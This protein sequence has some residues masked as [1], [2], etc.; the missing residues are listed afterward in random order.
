MEAEHRKIVW[1]CCL[2]SAFSVLFMILG[3]AICLLAMA[4]G[5]FDPRSVIGDEKKKSDGEEQKPSPIVEDWGHFSSVPKVML[6]SGGRNLQLTEDFSY[7]DPDKKT[8]V[9][10]KDS[11]VDGASIPKLF[12]SVVGGP[13]EGQYRN[14]SIIH[15]VGCNRMVESWQ[16]VHRVFYN[17][18]RCGGGGEYQAKILYTAV[19]HFGPRWKQKIV[20][21]MQ[22]IELPDGKKKTIEI[23][24]N[25]GERIGVLQPTE[26]NVEEVQEYLKK[27]PHASLDDLQKLF[28]TE[29]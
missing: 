21:A 10:P 1:P 25:V 20:A 7:T 28:P 27:N 24:R 29:P 8:W 12:W 11:I 22:T 2:V 6:L 5:M 3:F 19:Y 4:M 23:K 17:A 18:C 16:D 15:D 9:A 14:A 13:L 26:K